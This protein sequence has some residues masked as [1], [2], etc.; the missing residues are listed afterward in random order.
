MTR[1]QAIADA[2][3][4]REVGRRCNL[5]PRFGVFQCRRCSWG[6]K[7]RI[8]LGEPGMGLLEQHVSGDHRGMP[9]QLGLTVRR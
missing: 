1:K 2:F 9:E 3:A 7:L 4:F 8:P 5:A 6:I